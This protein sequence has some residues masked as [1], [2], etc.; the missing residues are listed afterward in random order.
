[1][2]REQSAA[3]NTHAAPTSSSRRN[4]RRGGSRRRRAERRCRAL[5]EHLDVAA[6]EHVGPYPQDVARVSLDRSPTDRDPR[7]R[8]V[9]R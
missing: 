2:K 4:Q 8:R 1:M 7:S 9:L 5:H 3:R 6:I